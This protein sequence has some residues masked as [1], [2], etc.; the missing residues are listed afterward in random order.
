[1]QKQQNFIEPESDADF[2]VDSP[3]GVV[4][5]EGRGGISASGERVANPPKDEI[6]DHR[7]VAY[8]DPHVHEAVYTLV[9]WLVGDG[10]SVRPP[11]IP[12]EGGQR[13][14]SNSPS[15]RASRSGESS[16]VTDLRGLLYNSQFWRVFNDWVYFSLVD[17]HGFM[18]LVVEDGVF[19]PRVLPSER[20]H[21]DLDE[22]GRPVGYILEPPDG[23]P[24]DDDATEYDPHEVAELW[25]RKEPT[26]DFGRS[27][28]E[29][30]RESADILRD[31]EIDYARFIATK[32]YPPVLWKLGSEN[33]KWTED[34]IKG[35]MAK[36]E[37]IGPD[38]MLFGPH[39]V[40]HDIVGTTSTSSTAGAMR[41]EET[42]SHFQDRI[43]TGLGVPAL[44]MNMEGGGQGQG[45]AVSA[46]PSFKRRVRRFQNIS[47]ETVEQEIF[48]SLLTESALEDFDGPTPEF[49]FG[50][51]SN[52]EERL[53]AD[54]AIKLLNNGLLTPTAAARR[55]GIDPD[56]ELPDVWDSDDLISVLNALASTGD[57]IQNPA[58]GS[59]TDTGGGAESA[60]GEATTRQ[61]PN[62]DSQSS[63]NKSSVA[64]GEG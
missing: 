40:D 8:T 16:N 50:E 43:V 14:P 25:F 9:D 5:Q 30:I 34:Q 21:R 17:G 3:K 15:G 2:A 24:E 48:R 55:A 38:S 59:P 13:V 39:D 56:T 47:K 46:M 26:D 19:K 64:E 63:R 12:G 62:A 61:D 35:W 60:G 58:G 28:V 18:E 10:Y 20:M 54:Q 49:E 37:E 52:A 57:S 51:H 33:E 42:F 6:E 44:I 36:V 4:V 23:G 29:P 31:M 27:V 22:F 32:A 11:R 53:D 1:M 41:L 7:E 45:E